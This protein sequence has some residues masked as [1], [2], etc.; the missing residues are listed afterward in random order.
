MVD[1]PVVTVAEFTSFSG[2]A[3]P[4]GSPGEERVAV[5]LNRARRSLRIYADDTYGSNE[6]DAENWSDAVS[7]LAWFWWEA[8]KA[9]AMAILAVP[10]S[11][12]SLGTLFWT[13]SA[14]RDSS[15]GL[16]SVARWLG[17]F[18]ITSRQKIALEGEIAYK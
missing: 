2:I 18:G 8:E 5:L 1:V 7:E 12:L 9:G 4:A 16:P 13:K 11:Q 3:L 10:V 15:M 17:R 14:Q 6:D